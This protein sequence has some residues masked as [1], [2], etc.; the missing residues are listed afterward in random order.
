MKK[1]IKRL[2]KSNVIKFI[3]NSPKTFYPQTYP[4][5]EKLGTV[6]EDDDDT[7]I[8]SEK[9]LLLE[10]KLEL[11]IAKKISTNQTTVP[12]AYIFKTIRREIDLLEDEG[13]IGIYLEKVYRALLTIPP[14]TVD[15]ERA[16]STAGNFCTKLRSRLNDS[17]IDALCFLRSHFKNL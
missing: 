11:S 16:F 12:K 6:N 3:V 7:N 17:T 1:K 5:A 9:K 15:A 8:D 13:F 4:H 14:T 10:Q 2:T